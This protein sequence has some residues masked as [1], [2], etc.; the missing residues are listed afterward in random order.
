MPR[1]HKPPRLE[2]ASNGYW[3]VAFWNGERTQRSS[4]ETKD[5]GEAESRFAIWLNE[6]DRVEATSS[7]LTVGEILALYESEHV[8]PHCADIERQTY[9]L[10]PLRGFFGPLRPQDIT[11][12]TVNRY[13]QHRR[14]SAGTVIRELTVLIAALN[15]AAEFHGVKDLPTIRKP[16]PPPSKDRWLTTEE[17]DTLLATAA[18]RRRGKA[19]RLT[20]AERFCWI[21]LEAP[22]RRK[23]IE[24]LSWPQVNLRLGHIDFRTPGKS[25]T[26]KRQV[27]CP[28]SDRLRPILERAWA[29]RTNDLWVLDL[30][31]SIKT[32]FNRLITEAELED[33]TPHTL[34]H[35]AATHMAQ[36]GV[37]LAMIA[38]ILGNTVAVVERTYAHWQTDAL[39]GAINYAR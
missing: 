23:T 26:K 1:E 30:P 35:T 11:P 12:A 17:I 36:A 29:E 5:A 16:S 7:G 39:R 20:R 6:R 18:S 31:G 25:Q 37:P 24:R 34:R 27:P 22:A 15:H 38:Q 4:L 3:N 14:V 21:A 13:A 8:L 28:I 9:A 32:T 19:Q 33:V 2:R 10:K